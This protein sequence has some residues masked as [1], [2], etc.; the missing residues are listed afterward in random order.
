MTNKELIQSVKHLQ[1]NM[2]LL[3]REVRDLK[4]W[5]YCIENPKA[6][7]CTKYKRPSRRGKKENQ[8]KLYGCQ[9][10]YS[11]AKDKERTKTIKGLTGKVK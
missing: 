4:E 9:H 2:I 7:V 6:P 8:G 3:L 1:E 11:M 10:G 5:K